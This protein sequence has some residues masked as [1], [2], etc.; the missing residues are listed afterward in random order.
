MPACAHLP[1]WADARGG[2]D[3]AF[4]PVARCLL[5]TWRAEGEAVKA[6]A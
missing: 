6:R 3:V 1:A 2:G 4:L 5:S